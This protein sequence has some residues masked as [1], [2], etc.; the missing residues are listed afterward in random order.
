MPGTT[1]LYFDLSHLG[2]SADT[3]SFKSNCG[4]CKC[5]H[6]RGLGLS[7]HPGIGYR[8]RRNLAFRTRREPYLQISGKYGYHSLLPLI[9]RR[10]D[11]IAVIIHVFFMLPTDLL[12]PLIDRPS[13]NFFLLSETQEGLFVPPLSSDSGIGS[14]FSFFL[15]SPGGSQYLRLLFFHS[16][17]VLISLFSFFFL[18]STPWSREIAGKIKA[19]AWLLRRSSF[20]NE[21]KGQGAYK[22]RR[23]EKKEDEGRKKGNNLDHARFYFTFIIYAE[24]GSRASVL[25]T[26]PVQMEGPWSVLI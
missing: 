25:A 20:F 24:H 15:S 21:K 10:A 16:S 17:K 14:L 6:V 12:Y 8:L 23:R 2:R 11:V 5:H 18:S 3:A 7:R 19:L 9:T 13:Q 1:F 26:A 4:A 22:P